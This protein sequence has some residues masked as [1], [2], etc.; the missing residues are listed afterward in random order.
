MTVPTERIPDFDLHAYVDGQL[1]IARRMD[2]EDY[3]SRHPDVAAQV[4]ADLRTRDAL[5]IAFAAPAGR[6]TP[7]LVEAG[8]RLERGLAFAGVARRFQRAA[9]VVALLS[10]GWAAH[11]QFG[12]ISTSEA[13]PS[14]PAFVDE[15]LVAHQVALLR[16]SMTSA[17]V[18]A[19][20][21]AE[22]IRAATRIALPQL[23]AD[24]QV[25]DVQVFPA[26]DGPS[27][28][29]TLDDR[30]LGRMSLFAVRVDDFAVSWPQ[31]VKADAATAAFWQIGDQAYVLTAS[32]ADLR[33]LGAAADRLARSLY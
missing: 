2:V 14:P 11:G 6:S 25:V 9:A 16:Q 20:L 22:E 13:A 21:D 15:A 30:K 27:V 33:D 28:E 31:E 19:H 3:L 8:R 32:A 12:G 23:P 1:D 17:A 18:A 24:W 10:I 29:L 26:G 5:R 7:R 4:M